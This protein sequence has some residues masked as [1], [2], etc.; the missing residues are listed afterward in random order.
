MMNDRADSVI[1]ENQLLSLGMLTGMLGMS[2]EPISDATDS[3]GFV[4]IVGNKLA[5]VMTAGRRRRA[6]LDLS[7]KVEEWKLSA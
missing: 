2:V 4:R 6:S 3:L 7:M 5:F 1:S